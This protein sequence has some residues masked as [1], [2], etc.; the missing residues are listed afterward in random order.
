MW[1]WSH[2]LVFNLCQLNLR[3]EQFPVKTGTVASSLSH[4]LYKVSV[5]VSDSTG[6]GLGRLGL[7]LGKVGLSL[8]L[9]LGWTGLGLGLGLEGLDYITGMYTTLKSHLEAD[10]EKL[11]RGIE[12]VNSRGECT[13]N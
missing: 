4:I 3:Y 5:S 10:M 8:G 1:I 2:D 13:T 12:S 7:G 6:L 9:G 11:Q